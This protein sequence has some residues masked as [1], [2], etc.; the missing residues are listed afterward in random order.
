MQKLKQNLKE[1]LWPVL[2]PMCG[3]VLAHPLQQFIGV[4][5]W[6]TYLVF[7]SAWLCWLVLYSVRVWRQAAKDKEDLAAKHAAA[8]AQLF[9]GKQT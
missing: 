7:G 5:V 9:G 2:V 8:E 1:G 4:P 6:L 3:V